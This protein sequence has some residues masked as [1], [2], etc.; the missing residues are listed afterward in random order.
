MLEK[1]PER[2]YLDWLSLVD[3]QEVAYQWIKS[4]L[5]TGS[6]ECLLK[7][8][9]DQ[10]DVLW[11]LYTE[12]R[13]ARRLEGRHVLYFTYPYLLVADGDDSVAHALLRWPCLLE[14]PVNTRPEWRLLID[15]NHRPSYNRRL[16]SQLVED[17]EGPWEDHLQA[18][19]NPA[20]DSL[21]GLS[22][23]VQELLA[24]TMIQA[25]ST[26]PALASFPPRSLF[27]K[28]DAPSELWWSAE[29]GIDSEN[30][31]FTPA[32]G[33][34]W[35]T[36]LS[37]E[38]SAIGDL[39][40][41]RLSPIQYTF[42][43]QVYGQRYALLSG[44]YPE[45]FSDTCLELIKLALWKGKSCLVI[46]RKKAEL[47]QRYEQLLRIPRIK[48]FAFLWQ[49]EYTDLPILA[50]K[51]KTFEKDR[52]I[53]SA[54]DGVQWRTQLN[55]TSRFQRQY[56]TWFAASRQA[57]FGDKG[58]SDLLGYYLH[59]SR[60]EG[61]ELLSSQLN[62]SQYQFNPLEY[63]E[64]I[65]AL[66]S[67]A[68]LHK[69]LNTLHHPLS[70]L[71]A[72]I[73]VHQGLEESKQ[74]IHQ[75]SEKLLGEGRRLHQRYVRLQSQ[76][77]D[78]L[79]GL[80]EQQYLQ[81]RSS[82]E[83]V[84]E[85]WED[86]QNSFG[87]DTLRS[88]DRT[89]KLYGKFSDKYQQA[90]Q[91]KSKILD[92]YA[93]LQESHAAF[94]T[95]E[96]GWPEGKAGQLLAGMREQLRDYRRALESWRGGISNQIQ[97]DMLRL[98]YKTAHQDLE[99]GSTI[100]KLEQDLE[101]FMDEVNASGLYQL[102]LQ[103]KTLTLPRQQKNLE[104][105]IDQLE[106]TQEGLNDYQ[107]FYAWQRNWFSLSELSRKTIQ[108]IL[109]SRPVDW[110]AAF[111][112]WYFYECLQGAYDPF[113]VFADSASEQHVEE[114]EQL[115]AQLPG[116]IA[117]D[118]ESRQRQASASLQPAVKNWPKSVRTLMA[119]H[120][121]AVAD[122]FPVAYANPETGAELVPHYDLVIVDRAEGLSISDSAEI[123]NQAQQ[124]AILTPS[125]L[126]TLSE[127]HLLR[128]LQHGDIP[129]S[130]RRWAV[131]SS[132][133]E[134]W[135]SR[136][137][138]VSFQQVDGRY[139]PASMTNEVEV[140]EIVKALNSIQQQDGM[141][142]PRLGILCWTKAQRDAIQL[143]LYRIKR[144]RSPGTDLILQLERNGMT[145][146][147]VEE[148]S[149]QRFDELLLSL[150]FGPVDSKGHLPDALTELNEASSRN[151]LNALEE[152]LR[153]AKKIRFL[154]SMPLDEVE[155]RLTWIDRPGERY[156]ALLTAAAQAMAEQS[157]GRLQ[158]LLEHWPMP[159]PGA[160]ADDSLAIELSYR[161]GQLLPD[162]SW[163]FQMPQ[164]IANEALVAKSPN[165]SR[166]VL[167]VDGFVANRR[168]TTQ[169]WEDWQ[170][171]RLRLAGYQILSYSSEALWKQPAKTCHRLASQLVGLATNQEEE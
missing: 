90:L 115:R 138:E 29:L 102:P 10:S 2:P 18:A 28:N 131:G 50:G 48:H 1:D 42:F 157:Y 59:F 63:Q 109:R 47:E 11:H 163:S 141:R 128:H 79:A 58:W 17:I 61:K 151:K 168:N 91:Q 78:Q 64:I 104:E 19:L 117:K 44:D 160:K 106:Q 43:R 9:A 149:G 66:E 21:E 82:L 145:I 169:D 170:K 99:S 40:L 140:Q 112:S 87:T 55:R 12:Q 85:L 96:F 142:Y 162:W 69:D 129:H 167:L 14:P 88:G 84:E 31:D 24:K 97:E 107:A 13:S 94:R 166:I 98:N 159:E 125:D 86:G 49:D 148:A 133:I 56:D 92:T 130:Q 119:R 67:T 60:V 153:G 6:A 15:T 123:L 52:A 8:R 46:A 164:G 147:S 154:N 103:S 62:A 20:A 30:W 26:Y 101:V 144:E 100:E 32:I 33:S 155:A 7:A 152:C 36:P 134:F 45:A 53:V 171:D 108:A 27:P 57:I 113:P 51:V 68:P 5:T 73:F 34:H 3:D 137:T 135:T 105:I 74:F 95:F 81:L 93:D 22:V 114:V 136:N 80:H 161:L 83:H 132:L 70:N 76:Y 75:T 124:M 116:V 71:S 156:V 127:D 143:M 54:Y 25:A 89:L 39:I 121:A 146:L 110:E 122:L 118:W 165:G 120:G 111:S 150:G 4:L 72:A 16:F 139:L 37:H 23:F 41:A 35:K 158:E 38:E 77:A 126:S 65:K